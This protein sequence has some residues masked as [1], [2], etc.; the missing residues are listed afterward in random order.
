MSQKVSQNFAVFVPEKCHLSQKIY[1]KVPEWPQKNMA[2]MF[3]LRG[4]LFSIN[5]FRYILFYWPV[6]SATVGIGINMGF[7]MFIALMSWY[8]FLWSNGKDEHDERVRKDSYTRLEH[9]RRN[10]KA[11]LDREREGRSRSL[12]V[13]RI[14]GW[15]IG[16][17]MSRPC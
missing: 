15:N 13:T 17:G 9:R 2:C 11:M 6:L 1:Q 5:N 14:P 3:L 10:V 8:Q 7:L 4:I 12:T 16:G